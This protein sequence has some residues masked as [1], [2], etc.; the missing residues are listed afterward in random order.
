MSMETPYSQAETHADTEGPCDGAGPCL[1]PGLDMV[2]AVEA[3]QVH[4]RRG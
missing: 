1:G 2:L 3:G 4:L